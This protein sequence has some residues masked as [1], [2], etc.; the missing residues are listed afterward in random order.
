MEYTT[1]NQTKV[2]QRIDR[3]SDSAVE[4]EHR[5]PLH[6]AQETHA[7]V[8]ANTQTATATPS[9]LF[10][11]AQDPGTKHWVCVGSFVSC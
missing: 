8:A 9:Y 6:H 3:E 7:H 10:I 2:K 5:L 4:R 1:C 11:N